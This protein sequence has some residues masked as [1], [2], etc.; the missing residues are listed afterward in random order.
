[1][2][3]VL[4]VNAYQQPVT[5]EEDDVE[6]EGEGG[7]SGEDMRMFRG[8]DSG[9]GIDIDNAEGDL[10]EALEDQ[11]VRNQPH[12]CDCTESEPTWS[13]SPF[14]DISVSK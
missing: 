3:T 2:R 8:N 12:C 7:D 4:I 13:N 6:R 1:M 9:D 14:F 11:A 5:A 10:E